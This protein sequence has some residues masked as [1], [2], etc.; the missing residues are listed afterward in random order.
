MKHTILLFAS[1]LLGFFSLSCEED[2]NPKT[3]F[4]EEQVLTCI[5][6]TKSQAYTAYLTNLYDVEGTN[7]MKNP[8]DPVISGAQV[9]MLYNGRTFLFSEDTL[10]STSGSRYSSKAIVYRG[11]GDKIGG[12]D[13]LYVI[14]RLANGK[15]LRGATKTPDDKTFE[16]SYPF[17]S[18]FSTK[19][20]QF[21][22]GTQWQID[23]LKTDDNLF[24]PKLYA[25]YEIDSAG[26]VKLKQQELPMRYVKKGDTRVPVYPLPTRATSILYSYSAIDSA[27][28]AIGKNLSDKTK[29]KL[30]R[31]SFTL[32]E[33]DEHLT[34]YYL[35]TNGYLDQFS[36]RIDETVYGNVKNGLGIVAS[37]N[38]NQLDFRVKQEYAQLFGY[39]FE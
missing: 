15:V 29:I 9:T 35:S 8:I 11:A 18:G 3:D 6:A 20:N 39:S 17:A 12:H 7:P 25:I 1:A 16:L 5:V 30:L 27:V 13:S 2:F 37:Y 21:L 36:I 26:I 10:K 19:I 28:A 24:I 23:W 31:I 33:L 4:R 14:A 22:W 32:V 34:K 38:N